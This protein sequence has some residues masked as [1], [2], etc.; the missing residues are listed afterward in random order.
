MKGDCGQILVELLL[1]ALILAFAGS[2]LLMGFGQV[3]T[4]EKRIWESFQ[5]RT[6]FCLAFISIEKDLRNTV[7]LRGAHFK[8]KADEICFPALLDKTKRNGAQTHDI[9]LIRYFLKDRFLVRLEQK[10]TD[11]LSQGQSVEH[12][13]VKNVGSLLFEFPYKDEKGETRFEPFWLDEPYYGI[14]RA[15]RMVIGIR[16]LSR[17]FSLSKVMEI[18]QGRWGYLQ[19]E[20]T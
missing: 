12:I 4:A 8:G 5:S 2:G 19:A 16:A 18:P 13:L 6:P 17:E 1:A 14:P 15:V 3:F 7:L 11:K 9:F 10:W 20:G